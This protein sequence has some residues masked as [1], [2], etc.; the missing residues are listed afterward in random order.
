ME[1]HPRVCGEKT[2]PGLLCPLCPG[3]PP[4][5]RG[6]VTQN[7]PLCPWAGITPAYA[8]KSRPSLSLGGTLWDHPR[9]CGE[10]HA[11][12]VSLMWS[13]GSPPRMRGKVLPGVRFNVLPGITPAY[14]GKSVPAL[15][16]FR[17]LWDHP[18]VCGE[19]ASIRSGSRAS[20][21]SPPRMRGKGP[22][23]HFNAPAAG[24]TPAYAGKSGALVYV[25]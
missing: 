21:G 11:V 8:G 12:P 25:H 13:A 4:R 18:R 5:M 19:K 24:I 15:A 7:S 20:Q 3:S 2:G 23:P 10:K 22:A 1:D 14:A 16:F 9:V 17:V 6:K